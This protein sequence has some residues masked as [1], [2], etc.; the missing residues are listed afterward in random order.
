[1]TCKKIKPFDFK[2]YSSHEK[3]SDY[4]RLPGRLLFKR[5]VKFIIVENHFFFLLEFDL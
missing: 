2:E 4:Q 1:M 5:T 3:C